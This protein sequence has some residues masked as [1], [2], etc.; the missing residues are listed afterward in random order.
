MLL[1]AVLVALAGA[2]FGIS[3]VT[4][5][6]PCSI[7]I[8]LT[9]GCGQSALSVVSISMIGRWFDRRLALATTLYSVLLCIGFMLAFGVVGGV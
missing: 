8:T 3:N 4:T 9:R 1:T 6:W 7:C 5:F 2:V